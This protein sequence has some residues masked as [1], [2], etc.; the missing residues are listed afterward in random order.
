[1]AAQC[2]GWY[3]YIQKRANGF[4]KTNMVA[5]H[6]W[7]LCMGARHGHECVL[8][9]GGSWI[10]CSIPMITV[11]N[12]D[13]EHIGVCRLNHK[14]LTPTVSILVMVFWVFLVVPEIANPSPNPNLIFDSPQPNC[15]PV[16]KARAYVAVSTNG[17][18]SGVAVFN[19]Q[20]GGCAHQAARENMSREQCDRVHHRSP[21]SCCGIPYSCCVGPYSCCVIP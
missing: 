11:H 6:M 5:G 13:G 2:A 16:H 20:N 12:P 19:W 18:K 1:M 9:F 17:G 14:E 10:R 4:R 3:E 8:D 7:W 15:C 21:Y